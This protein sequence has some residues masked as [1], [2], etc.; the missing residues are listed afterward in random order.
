MKERITTTY[1][2]QMKKNNNKITA[3]TA[4]DVQMAQLLDEAGVELLLVGDSLGMVILGY[5]NTL[6]VTM[7]DVLHHTKAVARGTHRALVIADMPFM[8]Y[9]TSVQD[10][11]V[12]AGRFLK[13]ADAHGVKLEGGKAILPQVTALVQAGIP[14]LGHI[15]LTPQ[16]V[17]QLGGFKV[18]G[19]DGAQ[20]DRLREE[21]RELEEAGV[22]A[23]VLECVPASLA[24][25]ISLSLTIPTIGI[26]AGSD[27]DGQI[28]VINDLLG[29]S[30]NFKPK[31]VR[32]YA[33]LHQV[34]TGAVQD[35]I[36]DVKLQNFPDEGES[37]CRG[38]S[39]KVT[40]LYS[41]GD[42]NHANS[43]N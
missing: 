25:E 32:R 8:S 20:A 27:C 36:A 23:I 15:G 40:P 33:E 7:E 5:E 2:T 18:Q 38:E 16:S 29:M 26:G 19:R 9:Q 30:A 24:K 22:F 43:K 14:V 3:L 1:L 6:A 10:A 34:I 17:H 39:S 37:F 31:F 42:E 12:N 21:A 41:G 4:Y 13:E 28:L 11:L 35:Y